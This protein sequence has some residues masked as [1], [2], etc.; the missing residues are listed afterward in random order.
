MGYVDTH[1]E[2][3]ERVLVRTRFHPVVF[4]GTVAFTAFVIGAAALIVARNDLAGRT[5]VLLWAATVATIVCSWVSPLVRWR[6]SEF[7]ATSERLLVTV[8]LLRVRTVEAAG[9]DDKAI[10]VEH[11]LWGRWLGYGTLVLVDADGMPHVFSRVARA[12]TLPAALRRPASPSGRS[13]A[14]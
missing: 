6:T 3:G 5:V 1:L 2:P 9:T 4:G 13:R 8:G 14:R 10:A 7:V 11:T 12:E